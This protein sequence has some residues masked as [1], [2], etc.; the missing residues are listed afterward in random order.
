MAAAISSSI[1]R[2]K[3]KN[4]L[5]AIKQS[6]KFISKAFGAIDAN[7][8]LDERKIFSKDEKLHTIATGPYKGG[9]VKPGDGIPFGAVMYI[10][11]ANRTDKQY[12]D[13]IKFF[14]FLFMFVIIQFEL[15]RVFDSHF[16]ASGVKDQL[17]EEWL[18]EP[19]MPNFPFAD[20]R[21]FETTG[22]WEEFFMW[23]EGPF[24]GVMFRNTWYNDQPRGNYSKSGAPKRYLGEFFVVKRSIEEI[25][26]CC[27]FCLF[28][29]D[30]SHR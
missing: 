6:T 25:F 23:M 2:T 3:R 29:E 9:Q 5:M 16:Q 27:V 17:I 4:T 18:V 19:D 13:L 14:V 7:S 8:S 22:N 11:R 15:R 28:F 12:R 20:E 21:K 24:L 10:L 1:S 26:L 30:N